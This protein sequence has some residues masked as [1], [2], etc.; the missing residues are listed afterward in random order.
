M[1]RPF[2][3]CSFFTNPEETVFWALPAKTG[4]DVFPVTGDFKAV[5][6]RRRGA[7][8]CSRL[9]AALLL[10]SRLALLLDNFPHGQRVHHWS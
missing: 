6:L 1:L 2:F 5:C 9:S 10:R 4:D 3:V 7:A 8:V